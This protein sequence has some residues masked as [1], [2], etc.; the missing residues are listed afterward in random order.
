MASGTCE[1][2]SVAWDCMISIMEQRLSLHLVSNFLAHQ[3]LIVAIQRLPGLLGREKA[4]FSALSSTP[5]SCASACSLR[6]S[7]SVAS[8]FLLTTTPA[9]CSAIIWVNFLLVLYIMRSF[10]FEAEGQV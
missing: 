3:Q 8:M 4:F 10:S 2:K 5:N 6:S 1:T 7:K 9:F